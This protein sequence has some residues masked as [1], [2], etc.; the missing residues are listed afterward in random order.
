MSLDKL[1]LYF[2]VP[3]QIYHPTEGF[4]WN[5]KGRG[6]VRCRGKDKCRGSGRGRG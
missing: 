3:E 4:A 6:R 1:K 5:V 2:E